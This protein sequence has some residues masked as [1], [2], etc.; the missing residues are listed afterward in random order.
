MSISSIT[1]MT[2][3]SSVT[4]DTMNSLRAYS[5]SRFLSYSNFDMIAEI[6]VKMINVFYD[7]SSELN[8]RSHIKKQVS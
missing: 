8:K 6:K 2:R 5:F 4:I 7:E 1:L 3:L